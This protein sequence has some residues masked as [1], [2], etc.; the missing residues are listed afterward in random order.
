MTTAK[1]RTRTTKNPPE[2]QPRHERATPAVLD[3]IQ[4]AA[5]I[6]KNNPELFERDARLI[7]TQMKV[8]HAATQVAAKIA[9]TNAREKIIATADQLLPMAHELASRSG[10]RLLAVLSKIILDKNLRFTAPE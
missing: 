6:H 2:P 1:T 8:E 7:L 9:Q 4:H 5:R 10:P 3:F